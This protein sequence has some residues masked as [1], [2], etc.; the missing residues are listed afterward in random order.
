MNVLVAVSIRISGN[1]RVQLDE[2]GSVN[3]SCTGTG[4][5]VPTIT[6]TANN[7]PTPYMQ[8]DIFSD[9]SAISAI[10]VTQGS[11]KSTLHIVN[12]AFGGEFACF[13]SNTHTGITE[14]SSAI[15]TILYLG[16]L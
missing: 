11:V 4:I 7:Q 8:T 10:E 16:K 9:Y 1:S 15:I 2:G 14:T 3:I 13:G 12:G 6:W 5:P